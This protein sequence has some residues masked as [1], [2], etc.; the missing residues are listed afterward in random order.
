MIITKETPLNEIIEY[1]TDAYKKDTL[2]HGE[3]LSIV[4]EM[5]VKDVSQLIDALE[6]LENKSKFKFIDEVIPTYNQ[7]DNFLYPINE[8]IKG[9]HKYPFYINKK[10]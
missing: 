8:K 10:W 1:V 5:T 6:Q 2:T 7:S 9:K 3:L 4:K